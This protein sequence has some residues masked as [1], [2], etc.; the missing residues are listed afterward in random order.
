MRLCEVVALEET[1]VVTAVA[2]ALVHDEGA[3]RNRN[4]RFAGDVLVVT[5][6]T[7]TVAAFQAHHHIIA[8]FLVEAVFEKEHEG[9]ASSFA[10]IAVDVVS[11]D[12]FDTSLNHNPIHT[13]SVSDIT[14]TVNRAQEI[15][16]FKDTFRHGARGSTFD[17][18]GKKRQ[19]LNLTVQMSESYSSSVL[20]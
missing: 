20:V 19:F 1:S 17:I 9:T 4:C 13:F 14:K 6:T 8:L 2:K 16:T 15:V 7:A 3:F 11:D 5:V 10:I 18:R 12:V